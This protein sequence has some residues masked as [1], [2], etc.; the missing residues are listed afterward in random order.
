MTFLW[1][2]HWPGSSSVLPV[3]PLS[4]GTESP[5][6]PNQPWWT[7]LQKKHKK[8]SWWKCLNKHY[9]HSDIIHIF[10]YFMN[11]HVPFCESYRGHLV[12]PYLHQSHPGGFQPQWSAQSLWSSWWLFP[13][14]WAQ[15]ISDLLLCNTAYCL[16][17]NKLIKQYSVIKVISVCVSRT[18]VCLEHT[19]L[20]S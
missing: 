7:S 9:H 16:T 14:L 20:I 2:E 13:D 17:K 15:I 1:L 6:S 11:H 19:H 8:Y 5:S 3:Y 10:L 12:P 4:H 18:T